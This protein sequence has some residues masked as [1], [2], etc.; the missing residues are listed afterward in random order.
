MALRLNLYHEIQKEKRAKSRDPLKLSAFA[1]CGVA[2]L[3][4]GYY[5]WQ[6]GKLSGLTRDLTRKKAEFDSVEPQAKAAKKRQEE[7]SQMLKQSELLVKRI[8]GRFYWAPMLGQL[9]SVVPNEVQITKLSGDLQGEGV[10]KCTLTIDGL[11][12]GPDPR[13][14]AEELRTA[15]AEELSKNYQAV[16]STFR[17]L[18][19]GTEPVTFRGKKM[20]T[21]T[22]AINI[23]LTCGK[24]APQVAATTPKK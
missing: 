7:V 22:F 20:P 4:A 3:F 13:K 14:V 12:A 23:Q 9:A 10:K 17:S 18:E 1:M 5:F 19:D 2:L 21:A 15:I 6:I 16:T 8:E 11:S 24:E